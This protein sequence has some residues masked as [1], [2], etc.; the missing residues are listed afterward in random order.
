MLTPPAPTNE[1]KEHMIHITA[2]NKAHEQE[3]GFFSDTHFNRPFSLYEIT[4]LVKHVKA[5]KAPG[6]DCVVYDVLKNL[7]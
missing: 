7:T 6:I 3:N 1:M 4:K 2:T 5:N